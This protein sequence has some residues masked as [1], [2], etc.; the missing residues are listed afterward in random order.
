MQLAARPARRRHRRR[1]LDVGV[2]AQCFAP[3]IRCAALTRAKGTLAAKGPP[4]GLFRG[5][6]MKET[7]N[8]A[9]D[10]V[11]NPGNRPKVGNV[12]PADRLGGPKV[13]QEGPFPG[14]P[15]AGDLVQG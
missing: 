4:A 9:G 2:L 13:P 6:L 8:Q 7:V 11:G 15:D 10:F 5:T 1:V 14:W 3:R 12:G